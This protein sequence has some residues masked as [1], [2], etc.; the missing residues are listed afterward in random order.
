MTNLDSILK[1]RDITLL[2][3]VHIV[4]AMIF[5]LMMFR[6]ESWI[7]KKAEHWRIDALELWCW[8]KLF[9]SP[10]H[11]KEISVLKEIN[12]EYSLEGLMLKLKFQYFGYLMWR[13]DSLGK[14]LILGK[15]EG[16]RRRGWQRI[17]LDGITEST[18]MH[19]SKL[20]EIMKDR[21]AWY[22][23]VHVVTK[24][25][26]WL[27]SLNNN[28]C[29]LR[30]LCWNLTSENRV[31]FEHLIFSELFFTIFIFFLRVKNSLSC[32]LEFSLLVKFLRCQNWHS[33]FNSYNIGRLL[34]RNGI[35]KS[36][37]I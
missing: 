28:K 35:F 20:W 29:L 12:P 8:R 27:K 13:T 1:S 10:L 24:S 25:W 37:I 33:A 26:T 5:P 23:A 6:S 2:T 16:G 36:G 30:K 7:I 11:S 21:E 9:E 3:K 18:D 4:K 32:I 15:I 17:W 19:L 34:F 31:L 22:A 14:I